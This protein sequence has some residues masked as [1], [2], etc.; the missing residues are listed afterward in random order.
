MGIV[1]LETV[2][3]GLVVAVMT[4]GIATIFGLWGQGD[5]RR[6]GRRRERGR[7][8]SGSSWLKRK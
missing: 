2:A 8:R 4:I 7:G 5:S 6:N 1:G 3:F